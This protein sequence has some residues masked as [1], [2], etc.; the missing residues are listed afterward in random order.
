M[1]AIRAGHATLFFFL[2]I[3]GPASGLQA[4]ASVMKLW[5]TTMGSKLVPPSNECLDTCKVALCRVKGQRG[6][7]ALGGD[8]T[9]G[10]NNG[11]QACASQQRMFGYM[12]SSIVPCQGSTLAWLTLANTSNTFKKSNRFLGELAPILLGNSKRFT[13]H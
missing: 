4:S 1:R 2:D 3:V 9:V 11:I 7:Q 8:E 5:V 13:N 10:H 12:Q 6:L